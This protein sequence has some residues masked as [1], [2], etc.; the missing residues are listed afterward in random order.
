MQFLERL[1][2]YCVICFF[3]VFLSFSNARLPSIDD[4]IQI[5]GVD[6]SF[7]FVSWTANATWIKLTQSA[8]GTPYY[9]KLQDQKTVVLESFQLNSEIDKLNQEI[10]NIYSNPTIKDPAAN[11]ITLR[12]AL[13][14]TNH[15]LQDISP[16][17]ES[18]LEIQVTTA[19]NDLGLTTGGQP[20]PW[21]LYHVTPLPQNLVISKREIIATE[22]NF[23]LTPITTSEATDLEN[24]ID[25]Q[26]HVSSL[27]VNIG[28]LAAYPTMIMQ[29]TSLDWL[30]NTIGHEW[31]HIFLGLRPLGNNYNS[32]ELRT[33]N[34]TTASIAGTEIGNIVMNKYYPGFISE[35][36][37]S[38]KLAS[39]DLVT[40][41]PASFDFRAEMHTTRTIV[42][43]LLANGDINGAE[44]YMEKQRKLFWD[45]GYPIRKIN[46][47]YFAFNGSYADTPGGAAGEDPVGPAVRELRKKS[48]S[49]KEFLD[50]ISTMT[51]FAELQ[52]ALGK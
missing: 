6:N 27:V 31:T 14:D 42:D 51:S 47:A 36:S 50:R 18:I 30:T 3:F 15:R 39:Y 49:L 38:T 41:Q 48:S 4:Q 44:N 35:N 5:L 33:M 34:E 16:F 28:G 21:V 25:K 10:N 29:S 9:I 43:K 32:P 52:K 13:Q 12:K 23:I 26:L 11:T 46:Q 20:I 22:A 2:N 24:A 17:S 45:N 37:P 40:S 7:D 19:L 8:I 1:S